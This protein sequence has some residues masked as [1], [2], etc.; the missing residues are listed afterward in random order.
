MSI[1][2]VPYRRLTPRERRELDD[3]TERYAR[4]VNSPVSLSIMAR[5]T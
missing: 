2:V 4:F 5:R 1:E 3:A